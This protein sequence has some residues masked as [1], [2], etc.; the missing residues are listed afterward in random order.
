MVHSDEN[1]NDDDQPWGLITR[2]VS[3]RLRSWSYTFGLGLGLSFCLILWVLL[4]TLYVLTRCC[5]TW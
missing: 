4:S 3:D 5:V 2:S 1:K